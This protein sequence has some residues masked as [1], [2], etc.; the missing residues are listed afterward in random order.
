MGGT[1]LKRRLTAVLIADVAG[2]SRLINVDE[3]GTHR[4]LTGYVKDLIEPKIAENHGRL[5]RTSGDGFLVEFDSS[6]DAV[7]CGLDT[8]RKAADRNA[9]LPAEQ[10][11]EFRI[12]IN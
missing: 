6:V 9:A 7:H 3:E 1:R 4:R 10:R 8:Q 12:G 11:I 2:Y 5:I